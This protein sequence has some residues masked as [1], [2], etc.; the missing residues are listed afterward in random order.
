[1]Q[2]EDYFDFETFDTKFG[3]AERIRI[4][5]HRIGIEHLLDHYK[6]GFSPEAILRDVYPTL[7]LEKIYA[8]ILYFLANRERV[9]S[10]LRRTSDVGEQ[11]YQ[12]HLQQ[13]E[14]EVVKRMKAILAER[15]TRNGQVKQPSTTS[16]PVEPIMP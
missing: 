12:E 9:E 11:F 13:P 16:K 5:G 3:P 14:T 8:T 15:E 7:N 1:M 4:K 10:Y 2:L 6:E